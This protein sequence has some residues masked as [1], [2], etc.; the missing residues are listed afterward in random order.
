MRNSIAILAVVLT[1]LTWTGSAHGQATTTTDRTVS[2]PA[3]GRLELDSFRG[4]VTVRGWDKASAH[5]VA[6]HSPDVDIDIQVEG[7]TLS[8]DADMDR[9]A[10]KQANRRGGAHGSPFDSPIDYELTVPRTMDLEID[11]VRGDIVLSGMQGRIEAETVDGSVSVD[12]GRGIVKLSSVQGPISLTGASGTIEIEAVNQAVEVRNV[13]GQLD[14]SGVNGAIR[15]IG[16][17]ASR[18][19]AGTVNG[20]IEWDGIVHPD[21]RYEFTTH[22]GNV[23]MVLPRDVSASVHVSTFNGSL[24]SQFPVRLTEGSEGKEFDFSLGSGSARIELST[25]NG[26]ITLRPT[27][28]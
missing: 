22:N 12:G 16:V 6:R 27:G 7:N 3:R 24:H 2:V 13:R 25:F 21:G 17:D 28:R 9:W 14:V 10:E 18:V 15:M 4:K 23:I 8:I 11:V 20:Q 1:A 26:S 5:I 19:E